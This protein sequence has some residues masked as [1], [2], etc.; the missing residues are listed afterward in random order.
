M[1]FMC[2]PLK[3]PRL[4]APLSAYCGVEDDTFVQRFPMD[5]ATVPIGVDTERIN[6]PVH[7][8]GT[9]MANY[10]GTFCW[11]IFD[12]DGVRRHLLVPNVRIVTA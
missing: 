8:L 4:W 5:F 6:I 3:L 11:T 10:C 9:Q 2:L 12:D 7:G 1:S